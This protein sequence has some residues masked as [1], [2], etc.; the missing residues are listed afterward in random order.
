M[1]DNFEELYN[2]QGIAPADDVIA[3]NQ[4]AVSRI[5]AAKK[6]V[7][8]SLT[9]SGANYRN[10]TH[11]FCIAHGSDFHTDKKRWRN[12]LDFAEG[13]DGIQVILATGDFTSQMG[14]DQTEYMMDELDDAAVTKPIMLAVGNHDRYGITNTQLDAQFK[15]ATRNPNIVTTDTNHLYYYVD[16]DN[17]NNETG[18]G[19]YDKADAPSPN[20]S[21]LRFIVLNQ[22]DLSLTDRTKIG[23]DYHFTQAQIN[24]FI[25]VLANTPSTTAVIVCMHGRESYTIPVN[26]GN[27][28]FSQR[29]YVWERRPNSTAYTGTIIEDII[30]AFRTG[31]NINKSFSISN[32]DDATVTVTTN[33]SGAGTFI[34]YM[35]GHSHADMVGYS[36][37]HPNQLYLHCPVS[38]LLPDYGT[39]GG[40]MD[41]TRYN[42]GNEVGDM[43]RVEGT[44]TQDCFNVYGIDTVNKIVKVVRVGSTVNDLGQVKD[45]DFYPYE[46]APSND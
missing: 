2:G 46:T 3:R 40:Y 16:Y 20:I 25:G 33:F 31:V 45:M 27:K 21:K 12:F 9:G 18:D 5:Y 26:T 30:E 42:V 44:Q 17:Y 7:M 6:H 24:W 41:N 34:A 10:T 8:T 43:P 13:V 32:N 28:K 1:N 35:I 36:A 37:Y 11:N 22:Y 4:D 23:V 39:E 19:V 29:H 15:M 38:C 14:Y